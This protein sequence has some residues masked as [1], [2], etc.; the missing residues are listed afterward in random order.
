MNL[1]KN[2][3]FKW[4][5][6]IVII[7][8][9]MFSSLAATSA[10][11]FYEMYKFRSSMST[12]LSTL[13]DIVSAS[14]GQAVKQGDQ[15]EVR[16]QLDKLGGSAN[17]VA[18]G[19]YGTNNLLMGQ[20]T[21]AG[22]TEALP[23]EPRKLAAQFEG[24]FLILFKPVEVDEEKVGIVYLKA[25]YGENMREH[26]EQYVQIA[27]SVLL[28]SSLCAV[29]FS[30]SLQR[31]ISRPI[32]SLASTA[33]QVADTHDYSIRATKRG[34][35]EIG[36][37]IDSFNTMLG[38]LEQRDQELQHAQ[39]RL[40]E[41]NVT[42]EKKVEERTAELARATLEAQESREQAE[43]ANQAKSA[44][45]A[46]MS[47]E[48][49]TPLNAIIGYS[50]MLVEEA[51]DLGE[52][53]MEVDLKKI[54]G[55]GR[56]LL[57]LINDILDLSKIEAGKMDLF[58][59]DFEVPEMVKE[60]TST[61]TPLLDKNQNKLVLQAADDLGTMHSDQT[62]VRQTLF[63]LLSNACKFTK[64]GTITLAV[65]KQIINGTEFFLF[66]VSDTGIGLTQEQMGRLFQAFSQADAGTTK[67]YGGTGLGLAITRRFCQMMGGDVT[68]SSEPGQGSTFVVHLPKTTSKKMDIGPAAK[69]EAKPIQLPPNA[70]RVLVIDDDPI[71]HDLLKRYLVKEGFHVTCALGGKEGMRLA[72]EI[73]PEVITLDVMMPEMDGWAVLT[74]LKADPQLSDIPVVMLSMV[75]DK[76]LGFTLGASEYLT[77]PISRERLATVLN[78]YRRESKSGQVMVVDDDAPSRKMLR[79]MLE[80]EGWKVEE[81]EGGRAALDRLKQITPALIIV[82]L[83][84][85]DM[86]G[87][88]F[89]TELNKHPDWAA[90]PVVVLTGTELTPEHYQKLN[91]QVEGILRKGSYSCEELVGQLRLLSGRKTSE[92]TPGKA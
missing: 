19:I 83:L 79:V 46:N 86:D 45:L 14:A 56:H 48:L 38:G 41:A 62:K 34:Q 69:S 72:K 81:A 91:G 64:Q 53:T 55:A 28:V 9:C 37:M 32:L 85:A 6:M 52:E 80:N 59:E 54:H 63:N 15:T 44:F 7:A 35:D 17:V 29:V 77:K 43:V 47:H 66:R 82:D 30:F 39:R 5:L 60:I 92:T 3:S 84:V 12:E 4:K 10:I 40:E 20:Y 58:L 68:V 25:D 50:E 71:I 49:R 67:K 42:L 2:L 13:A 76:N 36:V 70:S 11:I 22:S 57:A 31:V 74:A 27:L 65:E 87:M 24:D 89:L 75:D 1:F 8:A 26:Y 16:R 90:I 73:H 33:K 23:V 61:I 78:K 18:A 51:Q 88:D 21:R